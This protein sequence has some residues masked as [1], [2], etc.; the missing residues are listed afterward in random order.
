[1]PVT[2]SSRKE[3]G[4]SN[5]RGVLSTTGVGTATLDIPIATNSTTGFIAKIVVRAT[6]GIVGG[7]MFFITGS[8]TNAGGTTVIDGVVN[9]LSS[10]LAAQVAGATAV[11]TASGANLRLTVTGVVTDNLFFQYDIELINN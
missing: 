6:G 3:F 9:I 4:G 2:V 11:F 5:P 7:G 1:M 10:I 8:I